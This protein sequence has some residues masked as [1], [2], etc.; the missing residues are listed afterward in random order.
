MNTKKFSLKNAKISDKIYF[1]AED[2][3]K[4]P[5]DIF[6]E[7]FNYQVG[8]EFKST[9]SVDEETGEFSVPSGAFYKIDFI[10]I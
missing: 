10:N 2:L 8:D 1:T 7:F 5:D 9:W 6:Y 4:N 3:S